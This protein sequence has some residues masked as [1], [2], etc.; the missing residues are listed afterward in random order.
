M[1][2]K[3]FKNRRCIVLSHIKALLRV[4][5]IDDFSSSLRT[6]FTQVST[7]LISLRALKEP[8]VLWNTLL[9]DIVLS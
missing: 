6:M 3:R 8:V 9:I 7:R 4:E 1:L 2:T 5:P